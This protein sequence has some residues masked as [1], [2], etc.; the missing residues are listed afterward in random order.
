MDARDR[1][2]DIGRPQVNQKR[3]GGCGL[4]HDPGEDLMDRARGRTID[5]SR[6]DGV[7]QEAAFHDDRLPVVQAPLG[8]PAPL[9][10]RVPAGAALGHAVPG[11]A[12]P[13]RLQAGCCPQP[14]LGP[15]ADRVIGGALAEHRVAVVVLPEPIMPS[16]KISCAAPTSQGYDA[17]GSPG[18][19]P[20]AIRHGETAGGAWTLTV[21]RKS[22]RCSPAGSGRRMGARSCLDQAI[23]PVTSRQQVRRCLLD[24]GL[25]NQHVSS[26]GAERDEA[27]YGGD[28]SGPAAVA[29]VGQRGDHG[30]G[31]TA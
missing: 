25:G 8:Q 13:G 16:I 5:E 17:S 27:V 9:T 28:P 1:R 12:W 19:V 31:D 21:S 11:T 26:G 6:H 22:G 23:A 30:F 2:A 3:S 20:A 14:V 18:P 24:A 15:G 4:A 29:G 7:L 10:G